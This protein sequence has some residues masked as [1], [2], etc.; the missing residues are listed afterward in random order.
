MLGTEWSLSFPR[1]MC[2]RALLSPTPLALIH[3]PSA[4]PLHQRSHPS[5]SQRGLLRGAQGLGLSPQCSA[6]HL[7]PG[8]SP[9][10]GFLQIR[11]HPV[12]PGSHSLARLLH[13]LPF[14]D[15][16][17]PGCPLCYWAGCPATL[18]SPPPAGSEPS[19][20]HS[21]AR[22]WRGINSGSPNSHS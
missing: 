14:A 13:L 16:P 7:E 20:S 4:N 21:V 11:R 10:L 5:I 3:R 15:A 19:K 9:A 8:P 17:H 18:S 22:S 1:L 2:A 12:P 6:N